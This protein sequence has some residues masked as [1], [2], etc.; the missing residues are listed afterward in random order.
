VA[1]ALHAP[2]HTVGIGVHTHRPRTG[3]HAYPSLLEPCPQGVQQCLAAAGHLPP[4]E[5][6]FDQMRDSQESR[7]LARV[8]PGQPEPVQRDGAEPT[9]CEGTGGVSMQPPPWPEDAALFAG[10]CVPPGERN[11]Q[12]A[13]PQG[14][15]DVGESVEPAGPLLAEATAQ[16]VDRLGLRASAPGGQVERSAVAEHVPSCGGEVLQVEHP[17]E[18][19]PGFSEEIAQR[20]WD[21]E[22]AVAVVEAESVPDQRAQLT[23]EIVRR[24]QQRDLMTEFRYPY[25]CGQSGEPTTDNHH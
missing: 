22:H 7:A 6:A 19:A 3:Q 2:D 10:E 21:S 25:G 11:V 14:V 13:A 16:A 18:R 4:A 17:L 20:R 23:A 24:F 8:L 5:L 1:L 9:V 15:P 12:G